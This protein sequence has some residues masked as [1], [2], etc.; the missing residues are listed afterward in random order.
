M[1]SRPS[2]SMQIELACDKLEQEVLGMKDTLE[3]KAKA[4]A[5]TEGQQG[6]GQGAAAQAGAD[7]PAQGAS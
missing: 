7:A 6:E 5:G 2:N 4:A 3:A 1:P